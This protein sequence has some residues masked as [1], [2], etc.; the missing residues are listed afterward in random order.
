MSVCACERERGL[1]RCVFTSWCSPHI[2]LAHAPS[3]STI[4]PHIYTYAHARPQTLTPKHAPPSHPPARIQT[5]CGCRTS[6][7]DP[8]APSACCPSSRS[9]RTRTTGSTSRWCVC[10]YVHEYMVCMHVCTSVQGHV[11]YT[12]VC[13]HIYIYTCLH[14]RS[15]S[16]IEQLKCRPVEQM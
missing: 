10:M 15:L 12:Y 16:T 6:G 1:R 2:Q 7:Q 5:W 9:G 11:S 4:P 13:L 14:L 3:P 8:C